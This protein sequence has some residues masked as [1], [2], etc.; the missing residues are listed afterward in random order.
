MSGVSGSLMGASGGYSAG[1]ATLLGT[2]AGVMAGLTSAHARLVEAQDQVSSGRRLTRPSQD[3]I[4]TDRALE[5]R[6]AIAAEERYS[7][8]NDDAL[9][10]LS[11]TDGALQ[12]SVSTLHRVRELAVKAGS[13]TLS[14]VDREAIATELDELRGSLLSSANTTYLGRPVFAGT[15]GDGV[16][17]A[18]AG[19]SA[20]AT[21]TGTVEREL[22][23]GVK[24]RVDTPGSE[25]FGD[26]AT[27]VFDV[28]QG[29]AADVRAGSP[30][31]VSA[32]LGQ[33]DTSLASMTTAAASVGARYTHVQ[34]LGA[35]S[36]SRSLE[37]TAQKAG[38]EEVD[39]AQ[40]LMDLSTQQ[41]AYQ[42][43]LSAAAKVEAPSLVDF[44]R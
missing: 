40:A 9:G 10:W 6:H 22:A 43:A 17:F 30:T 28:V 7:R 3:V 38:V 26:G 12:A 36:Q 34:S 24:V 8:A 16:A 25:A 13:N 11:T 33:L 19:G 27:S 31:A 21:G 2:Q 41:T 1:R 29:L 15:S 42:A 14:A 23:R 18:E 20:V 44:L 4:G 32:R 37:L 39:L 35:T 5:V